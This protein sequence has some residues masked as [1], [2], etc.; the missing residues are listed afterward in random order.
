MYALIRGLMDRQHPYWKEWVLIAGV[1][2]FLLLFNSSMK[3]IWNGGYVFG[4]RYLVPAIPFLMIPLGMAHRWVPFPIL[5]TLGAVSILI[6][7]TGVQ[8]IVSQTA[9]GSLAMFALSGPTTQGYQFL[10]EYF[11]TM[12]GWDVYISPTGGFALLG[13]FVYG[14]WRFIGGSGKEV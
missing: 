5:A 1:L 14:I 12:A 13:L 2:M 4:P 3:S 6:N 10:T 7:W 9:F 11:H 8:Y